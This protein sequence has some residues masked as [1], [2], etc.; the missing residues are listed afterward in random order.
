M[1]QKPLIHFHRYRSTLLTLTRFRSV[2]FKFVKL[3]FTGKINTRTY[4]WLTRTSSL[5]S[6]VCVRSD[7]ERRLEI[8]L[9]WSSRQWMWI[10]HS[11]ICQRIT[12]KADNWECNAS[13][14]HFLHGSCFRMIILVSREICRKIREH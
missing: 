14:I 12:N 13:W 3:I 5:L 8:T 2:N 6:C 9:S 10:N 7:V 1:T 4:W 11:E